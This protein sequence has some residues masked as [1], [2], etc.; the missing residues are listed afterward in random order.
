MTTSVRVKRMVYVIL[1]V[2]LVMPL[3][4]AAVLLILTPASPIIAIYIT[5]EPNKEGQEALFNWVTGLQ[6]AIVAAGVPV[7]HPRVQGFHMYV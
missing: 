4:T 7:T 5:A 3:S 6:E 1:V 2:G